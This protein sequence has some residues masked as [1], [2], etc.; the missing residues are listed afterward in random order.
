[1]EFEHPGVHNSWRTWRIDR[2]GEMT[3]IL[4]VELAREVTREDLNA[5]TAAIVEHMKTHDDIDLT[6]VLPKR[7]R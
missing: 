1:M 6:D 4:K 7:D 2:D 3:T 5:I